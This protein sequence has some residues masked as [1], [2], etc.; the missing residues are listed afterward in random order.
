MSVNRYTVNRD[1]VKLNLV[2]RITEETITTEITN[3]TRLVIKSNS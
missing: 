1:P 3:L 2:T